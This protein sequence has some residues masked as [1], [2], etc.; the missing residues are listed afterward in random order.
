M[1]VDGTFHFKFDKQLILDLNVAVT[2]E[3][4]R[5]GGASTSKE[6]QGTSKGA[7]VQAS[8]QKNMVDCF[9]CK[10]KVD[11]LL[12]R[13]HVG[14]HIL[15]GDISGSAICGFCG[16]STCE[17]YL[18][19]FSHGYSKQFFKVSSKCSYEVAWKKTPQFSS[20]N[21]CSNHIIFCAVCGASVWTYNV[22]HHYSERHPDVEVPQ[23]VSQ[24]EIKKMKSKR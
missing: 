6:V 22:E 12:M 15:N 18:M 8:S 2:V 9:V 24:D 23:L 10:K 19:N 1:E 7:T 20:R 14:H 16:R 3:D 5:R 11:L 4:E 21:P 17:N 13:Q